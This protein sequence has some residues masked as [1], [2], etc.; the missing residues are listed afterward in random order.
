MTC[1]RS[2]EDLATYQCVLMR[3]DNIGIFYCLQSNFI[4]IILGTGKAFHSE[5]RTLNF[6]EEEELATADEHQGYP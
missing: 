1:P 4:I 2:Q 3:R 6:R 5:I